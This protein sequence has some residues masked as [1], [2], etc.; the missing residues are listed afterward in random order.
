MRT[1][2]LHYDPVHTRHDVPGHP[3]HPGR[4]EAVLRHLADAGIRSSLRPSAPRIATESELELAHAAAHVERIRRLDESGGQAIDPDTSVVPGSYAASTHAVGALLS[5]VDEVTAGEANSAY[6]LVRPPGHHATRERAMGFCLF[7]NVAVAASYACLGKGVERVA[8]VDFDVHHGNG[9]QDIFWNDPKV[10][11]LSIHQYPFYP[12]TGDWQE[13]GGPDAVGRTVNVPLP[14][15][16]GDADYLRAFDA[17]LLPLL[18]RFQPQLL[19][20]S[21]GYDAHRLD[22]LANMALSSE[23][24]GAIMRRLRVTADLSAGGRIVA[25]LEGGY[26]LDALAASV[27]ASIDPLLADSAAFDPAPATGA[28]IETYLAGLRRYHGLSEQGSP[29]QG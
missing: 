11:Y 1:V 5:A 4:V 14:A 22:P 10:L 13:T 26:N 23:A 18:Q 21:A 17:L 3:E 7:N 29:A 24:Y 2:A 16:S 19:L 9:T 12:G 27:K 28:R 20:V 6:C 25:A 8:I 15:G